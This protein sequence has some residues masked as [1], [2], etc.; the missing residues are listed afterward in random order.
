MYVE[1]DLTTLPGGYTVT[2][3]GASGSKDATDSDAD[4]TTGQTEEITLVTDEADP[5]WD[6][7]IWTPASLGNYVW[8]DYDHDG[9]QDLNEPPV[10]GVQVVLYDAANTPIL[11]TTTSITGFYRFDGLTPSVP[12]YVGFTPRQGMSSRRRAQT[13]SARW[14]AMPTR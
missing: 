7:G 8:E 5:T 1:F 13:R 4:P 3:Q 10:Q 6:M 2:V 11:T 14:T 9:I 12:Y